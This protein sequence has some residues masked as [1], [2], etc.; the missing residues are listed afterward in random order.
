[1]EYLE[2]KDLRTLIMENI[3]LEEFEMVNILIQITNALTYLHSNHIVHRDIKPD[4]IF[5]CKNNTVKIIDFG[6]ATIDMT[7]KLN[8]ACGTML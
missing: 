4:N 8:G 2:G 7:G 6:L 3:K 5:L 1:M